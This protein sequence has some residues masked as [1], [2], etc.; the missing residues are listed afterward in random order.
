MAG[1]SIKIFLVDGTVSGF[2][3]AEIG[4]STIKALVVPR[5][6]LSAVAKRV[7]L[8]KTGIY[9]LVG[10]DT[11]GKFNQKKIYIGEG[12]TIFTRLN[13]H[14]R[15]ETKDFWEE[16]VIFV[17][18]DENLGKSHVRYLEARL[19]SLAT[20]ARRATLSNGTNPNEQGRLPESDE[21][22]MEEF[23]LQARLLLGT[24][25]YDL[26]EPTL[27]PPSVC[28][29]GGSFS[30]THVEFLYSGDGFNAICVVDPD[31]GQFIVKFNSKLR[32]KEAPTLGGT[33]KNLRNQLLENGILQD[34]DESSNIFKQD[35]SFGS[36][37]A[38]AQVVSGQPING[39]TAW[40]LEN[41]KTFADWQN[42]Q[43]PVE[44]ES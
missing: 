25:G 3:T 36:I 7:E 38:A 32:K 17:S 13:A 28:T 16:A 14:N 1:R 26:F 35:Y 24:L 15:D 27:A 19:I 11:D 20:D 12:D 44:S 22:E 2:R 18:K 4:L 29:D 41:G 9:V 40:H 8:Q 42:E 10:P 6:S 30:A 23:I 21:N 37:S 39:R 43:I 34:F 5:A 33:Y 31:A